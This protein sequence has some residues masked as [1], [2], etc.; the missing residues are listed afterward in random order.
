LAPTL[1][2]DFQFARDGVAAYGWYTDLEE[3]NQHIRYTYQV[4]D[5]TFGGQE[6]WD[7]ENSKIYFHHNGNKLEISY[8]AHAPWTSRRG[9]AIENRWRDSKKWAEIYLLVFLMGA[10][11]CIVGRQKQN[12]LA[13]KNHATIGGESLGAAVRGQ[14]GPGTR[15]DGIWPYRAR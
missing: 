15:M 9:W 10:M 14:V 13:K 2:V 1:D 11:L 5:Q 3:Q 8:L 7:E 4:G 6:S 12:E